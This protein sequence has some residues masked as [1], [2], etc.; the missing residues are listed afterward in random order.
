M[1][2]LLALVLVLAAPVAT[3][4]QQA[5]PLGP[6]S[7]MDWMGLEPGETQVFELDGERLCVTVEEPTTIRD[8]RYAELRGLRW[9]GLASDSRILVPLEGVIGLSV[10]ATPGP[11][12]NPRALL[13]P[14]DTFRWGPPAGTRADR[15]LGPSLPIPA[16]A[17]GWYALGP[18]DDPRFLVYVRCAAC[19]DAGTRV[20][21]EKERGI[22]SV[23]STT[24]VGTETL[25]RVDDSFC[26][27][28]PEA[29]VQFQIYVLPQGDEGT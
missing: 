23:T 19:T 11:R 29:G 13:A 9:P 10:I 2:L 17:D 22:R 15:L 4:A 18:R 16:V 5:P 26:A 7:L 25:R 27:E 20:V 12:P 14:A 6:R 3:V 28:R 21:F 1:R 8:R 24:I